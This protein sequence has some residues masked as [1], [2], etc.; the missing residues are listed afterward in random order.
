[1]PPP[2]T[3]RPLCGSRAPGDPGRP[4]DRKKVQKEGPTR[5][6][7]SRARLNVVSPTNLGPRGERRRG[8]EGETSGSYFPHVT[9]G[10]AGAREPQIVCSTR[11]S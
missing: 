6:M 5:R 4:E 8:G 1:M 2:P 10:R 9:H 7:R 11:F 3:S